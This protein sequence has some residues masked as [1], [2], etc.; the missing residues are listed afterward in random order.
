MT[1]TEPPHDLD[2]EKAVLG[3]CMDDPAVVREARATLPD[4]ALFYR[5]AHQIIYRALLDLAED[6]SPTDPIALANHLARA[7]D[8]PRVGNREY[9]F[10][11]HQVG[12]IVPN[13]DFTHH[14]HTVARKAR[15]RAAQE[16][17]ARAAQRLAH[18]D[19]DDIDGILA[20]TR[21]LLDKAA[22][23]LAT[24]RPTDDR[25]PRV[26]WTAAFT[27]DFTAIDWLPGRLL[28]RGQQAALVG[29]GK[30]GKSL[31]TLDWI[32]RAI[33]GRPAFGDQP[34]DPVRVLYF[35][36]ENTLR[37]ITTRLIALGATH[38]DLQILGDRLD[39]R[40]FPRFTGALNASEQAAKEM[41]A[42]IDQAKPDVVILDTV[43]RFISGKEN[44]SDTW[45]EL[46]RRIHEPLKARGVASLRLDHFG[47]DAEKGSRGS[48]A[49]TQ[50][51]DH[52]WELVAY[53]ETRSYTDTIEAITT[54][55]RLTR[56]HTRT[57]LGEDVVHLTRRGERDRTA[58]AWLPGRTRHELTDG[59][60]ADA[61]R[62][63][64]QTFVDELL[65]RGVPAGLGRDA[66]K[67]WA[68]QRKVPLPG[69]NA[70]ISEVVAALKA[71]QK[72]AQGALTE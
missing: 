33:T 41:L 42:L 31:F 10:E 50:D 71:A 54:R 8:L 2:A 29:D 68:A 49:K 16:S 40:L 51:V 19:V 17:V 65:M 27:T 43:S 56:T 3:K 14:A 72:P 66:L 58:G 44:D 60:I 52:V 37:D 48:S 9:I 21:D 24:G 6:W 5:P 70:A 32:W 39:Y 69:K 59:S 47:K 22:T 25:F 26:D 20:E 61:H 38:D 46:Y 1:I 55:L 23:E 18:D 67:A 63:K 64:V 35:D 7:G 28:E 36:R 57:G 45:L 12:G 13:L 4:P 62:Q 11:L 53:D 34:R 30:V 15:H